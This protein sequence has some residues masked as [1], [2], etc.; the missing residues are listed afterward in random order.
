MPMTLEER[1]EADRFLA[2]RKSIVA[3]SV[4]R[5]D[6]FRQVDDF[7]ATQRGVVTSTRIKAPVFDPEN[8]LGEKE[9]PVITRK[10]DVFTYTFPD[11]RQ[12]RLGSDGKPY[13]TA[14]SG[15]T[16]DTKGLVRD[17]SF[18]ET[19]EEVDH[20]VSLAL[21][22]TNFY[23]NLQTSY[24]TK[25]MLQS[26]Y[27]FVTGHERSSSED[28]DKNNDGKVGFWEGVKA[29][30]ADKNRQKSSMDQ[31][32]GKMIVEWEAIA[33]YEKEEI[34][35]GE[36]MAALKYHN[37]P[38]LVAKFLRRDVAMSAM[39]GGTPGKNKPVEGSLSQKLA[40][41][42]GP[43]IEHF[44]EPE[45]RA[46]AVTKL[47]E[48]AKHGATTWL[49]EGLKHGFSG[50]G[51][52][53]V[54]SNILREKK[55]EAT[56]WAV[57]AFV[58][59]PIRFTI[60]AGL[61][62]SRSDAVLTTDNPITK[63]IMGEEDLVRLSKSES[64]EGKASE[65]VA[66]K[67]KDTG[68]NPTVS[69]IFGVSTGL[70]LG[71]FLESPFGLPGKVA[72]EA[73]E[74]GLKALILSEFGEN[75]PAKYL[76]EISVEI[77]KI[78]EIKD[79]EE[80][81][82]TFDEFVSSYRKGLQALDPET[83][84][85]TPD[86]EVRTW[87]RNQ[88]AGDSNAIRDG[89]ASARERRAAEM[90]AA[91]KKAGRRPDHRR[92]SDEAYEWVNRTY[93]DRLTPVR[94]AMR[95]DQS[96]A[97]KMA[98]KIKGALEG[99]V[100]PSARTGKV[101]FWNTVAT[102]PEFVLKK[103]GLGA[104]WSKVEKARKV[105]AQAERSAQETI[106]RMS[107]GVTKAREQAIFRYLDGKT[108]EVLS[109]DELELATE[110]RG[111][112]D[113]F[114]QRLGLP[115]SRK[116]SDYAPHIFKKQGFFGKTKTTVGSVGKETEAAAKS[117]DTV[118]HIVDETGNPRLMRREGAEGYEENLWDAMFNYAREGERTIAF[119]ETKAA[120]E[121][122]LGYAI[123]K[124]GVIGS[125]DAVKPNAE[126]LKAEV[127]YLT[128]Y[129]ENL[130][131]ITPK[132]DELI[133]SF[134]PNVIRERFGEEA[135]MKVAALLRKG[136]NLAFFGLNV[137][138]AVKN[139]GQ[140]ANA[141]A[142]IGARGIASGALSLFKRGSW[143]E[144]AKEGVF[145]PTV[146]DVGERGYNRTVGNVVEDA[147]FYMFTKV[148]RINR[149]IAYFGGKSE[150]L[151]KGKTLEEAKAYGLWLSDRAHF[152]FGAE[153]TPIRMYSGTAKTAFQY[154][155]Y[156]AK[157]VEFLHLL[158]QEKNYA[159]MVRYVGSTVAYWAVI[160]GVTGVALKDVF[161][162]MNIPGFAPSLAVPTEIIK[163]RLDTPDENGKPRSREQKLADIA[164]AGS[165]LIPASSQIK[166]TLRGKAKIKE[167][168]SAYV[169]G[170]KLI[171]GFAEE[172]KPVPTDGPKL[173]KDEQKVKDQ[174]D[175]IM[176]LP[177][178]ERVSAF[179][180]LKADSEK[181]AKKVKKYLEDEKLGISETDAKV[182]QLTIEDG[183]RALYIAKELRKLE[184]K[185]QRIELWN[186]YAEKGIITK[187]VEKQIRKML[188]SP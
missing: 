26:A 81:K 1:E 110:V 39:V 165:K 103:M 183:S 119:R 169:K 170:K 137:L 117:A 127:E 57:Q 120:I 185:E 6:E 79:V 15:L 123:E 151:R 156:V 40:G 52:V 80:R 37:D 44:K 47:T 4:S 82:R 61:E 172:D 160:T 38:V 148:E 45:N 162:F 139:F 78:Y 135:A 86:E 76:E 64:L 7:L 63:Y 94:K 95:T 154:L 2:R 88:D 24:N 177:A 96:P 129:L 43:V 66:G 49:K 62:L 178:S 176:A 8:L 180:R 138:S 13:K 166:K 65:F 164:E 174:A 12:F 108:D 122:K 34:T 124:K 35:F 125:T 55:Q 101:G 48:F 175:E 53:P 100:V 59:S 9:A 157:Q 21:G 141:Y 179:N 27:D 159:G 171:F 18:A 188:A 146:I 133:N 56:K 145:G 92:I 99:E 71:L 105:Y 173:T 28:Q 126:L 187:D 83:A 16:T 149:G 152:T 114:A 70:L 109:G 113:D 50:V 41:A 98:G 67:L 104:I 68:I 134:V 90:A 111:W 5:S 32:I 107:S 72:K 10:K 85:L 89:L 112:F 74:K 118:E 143:D 147:L 75:V 150:S 23:G 115:E 51:I 84:V 58:G 73:G 168:D 11:G 20:K 116:I 25:T 30:Y 153:N 163:A 97:G 167:D 93:Y 42:I 155:P 182:R 102:S 87:L 131:E 33:K 136:S 14:R 54:P 36:A 60:E 19:G 186:E 140:N 144:L 181:D 161:A 29:G 158:N 130:Q 121:A 184:N 128:R 142:Y 3:P 91:E 46:A 22:G 31:P 17:G 106:R 132:V 77:K 69:E